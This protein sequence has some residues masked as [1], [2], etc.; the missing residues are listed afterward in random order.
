MSAPERFNRAFQILLFVLVLTVIC[1]LVFYYIFP[2][3]AVIYH[4]I[5][6]VVLPFAL[7]A[8]LAALID[9]VVNFIQQRGK[10]GRTLAVLIALLACL[11]VAS[12]VLFMLISSLIVELQ[13][14]V[15]SLPAQARSLG[16]LLAEWINRLQAFYFSGNLPS[17]VLNSLQNLVN[18]GIATLRELLTSIAQW[19]I[20]FLGS[21]PE[22]FVVVIITLVATFFFSR[23]KETIL[24]G[25]RSFLPGVWAERVERTGVF[26]G[27]AIIGV[28]RAETVLI[29]LQ[30]I[31]TVI[32]LLILKVDYALT[33]AFVI[34]L[35]DLLPIVGPGTIYIPWAVWEFIQGRYGLGIALLILYSFIIIL[36]QLLQPKLVAVSLGLHPLTTLAALYA[37]LKLLGIAGLI[38][39]PL[40]VLVIKAILRSS[41]ETGGT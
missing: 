10:V 32:G 33:L 25:L 20:T 39:G 12:I 40:T 37:G 16:G 17:D 28:L 26:L 7:A 35:A 27:K 8:L 21:L 18:T 19:L 15:A 5:S 24:A 22:L 38:I 4:K 31:Q 34:G 11:G 1:L 9:P 41:K 36:R 30:I 29:S 3:V 13:E 2:A 6:S 14:L 23:D